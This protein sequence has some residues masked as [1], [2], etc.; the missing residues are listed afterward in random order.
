MTT[1]EDK[2]KVEPGEMLIQGCLRKKGPWK[3]S[4]DP[5]RCGETAG[6]REDLPVPQTHY[7]PVVAWNVTH[8]C[9]PSCAYCYPASNE[10]AATD[11]VTTREAREVLE[12]LAAFGAPVIPFSG[13]EPLLREDIFQL[14]KYTYSCDFL[15]AE[16]CCVFRPDPRGQR[17]GICLPFSLPKGM[18]TS[19]HLKDQGGSHE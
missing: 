5:L 9:N 16:P 3:R 18:V 13:G 15:G 7:K 12:D 4:G 11:E 6:R 10:H 14:M 8:R 19:K 2:P 17:G 1:L